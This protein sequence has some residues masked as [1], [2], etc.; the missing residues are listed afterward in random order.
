MIG[1]AGPL[2]SGREEH[3]QSRLDYLNELPACSVAKHF[4]LRGPAIQ[5]VRVFFLTYK[6][7]FKKEQRALAAKKSP[8]PDFSVV[9]SLRPPERA[10]RKFTWHSQVSEN[11]RKA[12]DPDDF[13]RTLGFAPEES[14]EVI[15]DLWGEDWGG[16]DDP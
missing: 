10:I 1:V 12:Q 14:D 4:F 7:R 6:F 16:I 2:K 8:P 11:K 13:L 3:F 9:G 5:L 15:Q